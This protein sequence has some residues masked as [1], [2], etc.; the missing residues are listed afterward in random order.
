MFDILGHQVEKDSEFMKTFPP[1]VLGVILQ[2]VAIPCVLEAADD[3]PPISTIDPSLDGGRATVPTTQAVRRRLAWNVATLAGDYDKIGRKDPTWDKRAKDA[4]SL[5]AQMRCRTG[6][7]NRLAKDFESAVKDAVAAG[8]DD[9]LIRY[10]N[11]RLVGGPSMRASKEGVKFHV[12]AAEG[13]LGSQYSEFRKYFACL[14]AAEALKSALATRTNMPPD[15]HRFRRLALSHLQKVLNDK[16]TPVEEVH[17]A[18]AELMQ[19]VETNRQQMEE[20]Y[21][22]IEKPLLTNWPD[23]AGTHLIKGRFYI[24]HAWKARGTGFAYKVTDEGWKLFGERLSVAE[25]SLEK[26]WAMDPK[27]EQI[28]LNMM[29][30]ELGQGEGRER[31]EMWFDRAMKL[32]T[33]SYAACMQKLYYLEPKWHGSQQEMLKFGRECLDSK[34]W[35]GRIPLVLAEAH[36]SLSRYYEGDEQ[37]AYWRQP[38]IWEDI[39]ASY[40]TFFTN[41]PDAAAYRKHYA[42]YA[43]RCEQWDDLKKQLSLMRPVEYEF[44]GGKAEYDRIVK[45]ANERAG[46]KAN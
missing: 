44:F 13:L 35:G 15:I 19:E 12:Q 30:V 29:T 39:K 8:C 36:N 33:N 11:A 9:P 46:Q 25:K 3:E 1:V 22:A 27:N 28:A 41:C 43:Y 37:K 21:F 2:L 31:M 38:R 7:M 24:K 40:E 14:R 32:N 26:A 45:L 6:D 18:C 16:S 4:M 34:T 42:R 5:F 10:F 17:E 23:E 20:F